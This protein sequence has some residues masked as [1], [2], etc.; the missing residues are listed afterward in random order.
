MTRR[1]LGGKG[2]MAALPGGA[3]SRQ[4]KEGAL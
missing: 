2:V 4:K 1:F 3:G